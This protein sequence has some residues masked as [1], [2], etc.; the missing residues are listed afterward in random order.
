MSIWIAKA[1][2]QKL[3]SFLPFKHK[4]NYFFQKHITKGLALSD[5][6]FETKLVHCNQHIQALK[7]YNPGKKRFS[8]LE[9]GTGWYPVVP[10][11]MY[12]CG[13]VEIY[14][15]DIAQLMTLE[16]TASTVDK[17][18]EYHNSNKLKEILPAYEEEKLL[19]LK[20]LMQT[21]PPLEDIL[22]LLNLKTIIGDITQN[23][24][25]SKIKFDLIHSNNTFEHIPEKHLKNILERFH[26]ILG[27]E[28]VMSHFIDMSDHFSHF[29][30]KISP[31]HF[32]KFSKS[33]W[34]FIDN[35]IQPQNRLRISDYR[36]LYKETG[37][38][39]REEIVESG[40]PES[41]SA[42][43]ITHEFSQIDKND[44]AITHALLIHNR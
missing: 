39:I 41:L 18:I 9:L 35:N 6:L 13:A 8:A 27:N 36:R 28:G 31:Y 22:Q 37:W 33:R 12:L 21:N 30:K 3:I 17:F 5:K 23:E 19:S 1:I 10:V 20:T 4:I 2:T 7:K 16:K 43:N 32:L 25:L 44:L 11:G 14:S 15:V 29:D 42:I 34:R 38:V 40:N 26:A 24:M